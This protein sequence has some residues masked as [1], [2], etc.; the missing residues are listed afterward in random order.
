MQ[1]ELVNIYQF[2]Y[3]VKSVV[4]CQVKRDLIQFSSRVCRLEINSNPVK[5]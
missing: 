5:K 2:L 4:I 3:H 1:Q